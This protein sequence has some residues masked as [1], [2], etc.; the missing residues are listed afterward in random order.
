MPS[1]SDDHARAR[2][3]RFTYVALAV[4]M[5]VLAGILAVMVGSLAGAGLGLGLLGLGYAGAVLV[6]GPEYMPSRRA[7]PG[8]LRLLRVTV[9]LSVLLVILV[10]V[11]LHVHA[12]PV[13]VLGVGL[14]AA[15]GSEGV[16]LWALMT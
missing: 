11:L 14:A 7:R 10:M 2:G 4:W 1:W 12:D 13:V 3:L 16:A 9:S 15:V 8:A 5:V 6:M